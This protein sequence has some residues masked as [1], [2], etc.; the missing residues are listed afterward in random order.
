MQPTSSAS[1]PSGA[2]LGA[3]LGG[4]IL[5][6]I[7]AFALVAAAILIP[8]AAALGRFVTP[9]EPLWLSRSA[10]FYYALA[11]GDWASTYQMG[12]PGVTLM[13]AGAAAFAYRYPE[14]KDSPLGQ[15]N[16]HAFDRYMQR[17][18]ETVSPLEL[19]AIARFI[20][21][22]A[23][24]VVLSAAY[25]YARRL[26]GLLPALLGAMMIAFDPFHL[27]LTRILHTDGLSS[28]LAL[29]SVLAYLGYRRSQRLPH[30]A[31][32]AAAAGLGW[33]TKSPALF[34]IP[35]IGLLA[36]LEMLPGP[37]DRQGASIIQRAWRSA[38]PVLTWLALAGG[39]FI[40]L[41]PAMWVQPGDMLAQVLGLA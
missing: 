2:R 39:V 28:S 30:L 18:S 4:R 31:V 7:V 3:R 6:E 11:H 32:S 20:L 9:D 37:A 13:W 29:L 19:L 38:W 27:A 21:V 1:P 35:V 16:P 24:T 12:H 8:R 36:L 34:T 33:L 10:N 26:A 5:V 17:V 22:L 15:A 40:L 25:A 14:Y 41:W 23:Q